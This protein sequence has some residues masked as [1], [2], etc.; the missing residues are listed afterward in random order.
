MT[1][2]EA[3]PASQQ[4][5]RSRTTVVTFLGA[6]VRP[7]GDW[8][9]IAGAIDLLAQVG[10]DA[11]SV[12]TAVHRLKRNGWLDSET[13]AGTRGYALTS[14]ARSTLAAG[15]EVIWHARTPADLADGWCIVNFGVP[16]SMRAKRHQLRAHLSHLGFGNVGTAL[17]IA[18]ARMRDAAERAVTELGLESYAAIFVGGYHGT[19]DLTEL[20]YSSWDLEAIDQSYRDFI[21]THNAL[22]ARLEKATPSGQ[23]AFVTYLDVVGRWRKLPFRDP[24]LPHDVLAPDWSAPAAVALFERLV[25]VLEKPAL[26]HASAHWPSA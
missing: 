18:P 7:L 2:A 1:T 6:V 9:P 21:A 16:E 19:Q 10:L 14:T 11:P 13:R 17:W 5:R 15:D 23:D 8:M 24:G 25:D 4:N 26:A 20:L 12:R 3:A 22:A